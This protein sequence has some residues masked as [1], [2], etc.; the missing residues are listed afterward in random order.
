MC[1]TTLSPE[2]SP[3]S[4][5]HL[6]WD[7][8]SCFNS[9]RRRTVQVSVLVRDPAHDNRAALMVAPL[10][11]PTCSHCLLSKPR[12]CFVVSPKV[13]FRHQSFAVTPDRRQESEQ[14]W[15]AASTAAV[16]GSRP[17]REGLAPWAPVRCLL[18]S[19]SLV[20]CRACKPLLSAFPGP[21]VPA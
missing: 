20:S 19:A 6:G 9:R 17:D 12:A 4:G 11:C 7:L 21:Q 10:S 1:N 14:G 8:V 5:R 13:P 16:S 18:W 2:L 3:R 15:A